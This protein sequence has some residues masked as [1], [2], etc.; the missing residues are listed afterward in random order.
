MADAVRL[1]SIRRGYDPRDF[2][3]VVFGGA[4][5]LHG[6]ALAKELSIPVVLVPPHPGITST[7]GCLLV[8]IRHDLTTMFQAEAS[9]ADLDR[10]EDDFAALE[11]EAVERLHREGVSDSEVLL[12]RSVS[13]RYSG[14]WRSLTV[15]I[16]SGGS[17]LTEAVEQFHEQHER[18]YSFRRDET[19]VEL[20]QLLLRATGT[21]PKPQFPRHDTTEQP[22]PE[23]VAHRRTYFDEACYPI[24]SALSGPS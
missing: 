12:E 10:L 5:G 2:A 23:A 4:G 1:I 22:A 9:T 15:P 17:A 24:S 8:D 19:P 18:E 11:S 13:M 14:Q 21:I 6:A 20:Y 7:Q 16:S 3:L